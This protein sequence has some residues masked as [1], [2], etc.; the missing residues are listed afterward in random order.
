MHKAP[1]K[2]RATF[3]SGFF[4]HFSAFLAPLSGGFSTGCAGTVGP[5]LNFLSG[6][7]ISANAIS[8]TTNAIPSTTN[9]AATNAIP[10][11][12]NAAATRVKA[13]EIDW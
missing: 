11:A 6:V 7:A 5:L 8:A 10:S 4:W 12:T 9:A 1:K 2:H 3:F 13:P